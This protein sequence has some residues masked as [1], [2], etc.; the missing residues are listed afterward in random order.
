MMEPAARVRRCDRGQ[1]ALDRGVEGGA[2]ASLGGP[3]SGRELRPAGFD[4]RQLGRVRRQVDE[5]R[6]ACLEVLANAGHLMSPQIIH[7]HDV[8]RDQRRTQDMLDI[9]AETPQRPWPR[10][11]S[12]RPRRV[13]TTRP[14]SWSRGPPN[15][16]ARLRPPVRLGARVHTAESWPGALPIRQ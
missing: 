1:D 8:P 13:A 9:R 3:Q 6:P 15:F 4:A 14:P 10:R 16:V 7:D 5:L 11:S 2:G 12:S